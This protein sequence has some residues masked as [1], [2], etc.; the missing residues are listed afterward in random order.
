MA[1][2]EIIKQNKQSMNA[3]RKLQKRRMQC[4]D[5]EILELHSEIAILQKEVAIIIREK[6]IRELEAERRE[7]E[8]N[9]N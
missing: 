7:L 8:D 4:I 6:K 5:A 1:K 9:M 2:E 3:L